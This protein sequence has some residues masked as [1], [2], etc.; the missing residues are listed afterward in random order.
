MVGICIISAQP[1]LSMWFPRQQSSGV[2]FEHL[3]ASIP[4]GGKLKA[5]ENENGARDLRDFVK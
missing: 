1:S 3:V 2:C 5:K 4:Q